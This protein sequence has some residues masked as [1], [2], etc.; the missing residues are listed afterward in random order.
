MVWPGALWKGCCS[1]VMTVTF[2]LRDNS[3]HDPRVPCPMALHDVALALPKLSQS[4]LEQLLLP[5]PTWLR[6]HWHGSQV[7]SQVCMG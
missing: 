5:S 1:L 2:P 7:G 3:A 6:F 4:A